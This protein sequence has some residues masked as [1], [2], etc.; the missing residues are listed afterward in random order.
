MKPVFGSSLQYYFILF[1]MSVRTE[2]NIAIN[3]LRSSCKV[4]D[5]FVTTL[6]KHD[7]CSQVLINISTINFHENF[8]Q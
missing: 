3:V 2:K 8:V 4:S 1:L 6:T 5:I 7:F